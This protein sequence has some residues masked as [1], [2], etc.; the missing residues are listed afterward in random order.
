MFVCILKCILPAINIQNLF[1]Q[2]ICNIEVQ[3][4]FFK[5]GRTIK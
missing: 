3:Y 1:G 5:T 4:V 2:Y